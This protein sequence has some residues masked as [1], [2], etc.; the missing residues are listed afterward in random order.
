MDCSPPGSSVH[1]IIQA[2]IVEWAVVQSL[3]CIRLFVTPWTAASQAGCKPDFS[4][5]HYLREF[6]QTHVHW[7]SDAI[8]PSHSLL[9][10]SPPALSVSQHQG[11]FQWVG[12][13]HQVAKV[14]KF[15]ISIS[16]S[17]EYSELISSR[18]DWFDLLA[19]QRIIKSLLQH[20]NSKA[21]I[22]QSSTFFIV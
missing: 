11:L 20:H 9:P 2:R 5:L 12:S 1:R 7:V 13:S 19:G 10:S 16:P 3:S 14:L 22:L 15:S 6:A 18:I 8:Q 4:V 21:S 17:N